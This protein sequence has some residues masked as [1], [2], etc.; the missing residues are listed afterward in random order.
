MI[1]N[2]IIAAGAVAAVAGSIYHL[3]RGTKNKGCGCSGCSGCSGE[4]SC[5][6]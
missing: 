5:D 3:V 1:I 6:H 4:K 2:V